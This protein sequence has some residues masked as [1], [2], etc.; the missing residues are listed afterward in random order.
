MN[1]FEKVVRDFCVWKQSIQV[2][3]ELFERLNHL[4]KYCNSIEQPTEYEDLSHMYNYGELTELELA[5][6]YARMIERSNNE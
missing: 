5:E 3:N 6:N 4:A 2:P 1:E